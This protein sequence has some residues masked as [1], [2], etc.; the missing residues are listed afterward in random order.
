MLGVT[1]STVKKTYVLFTILVLKLF[2]NEPITLSWNW[3]KGCWSLQEDLALKSQKKGT[4]MHDEMF[5]QFV[6]PKLQL[7]MKA[8][9]FL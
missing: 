8:F 2:E 5:A 3:D 6:F 4:V 7:K 1:S 9:P